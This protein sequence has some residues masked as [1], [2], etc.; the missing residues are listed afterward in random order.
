MTTGALRRGVQIRPGRRRP[1]FNQADTLLPNLLAG[2]E[3]LIR[4]FRERFLE[5]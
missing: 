5:E 4:E 1:T 3:A 2:P